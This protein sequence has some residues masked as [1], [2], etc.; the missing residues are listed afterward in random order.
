[1]DIARW[2]FENLAE[3][4]ARYLF[5]LWRIAEQESWPCP[6]GSG[7]ITRVVKCTAF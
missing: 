1:M 5:I 4:I 2:G 3:N 7:P 6:T